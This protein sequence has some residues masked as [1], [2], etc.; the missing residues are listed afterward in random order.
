MFSG[1]IY[2]RG[3]SYFNQGRVTSLEFDP[4]KQLFF[5]QVTGTEMYDVAVK[6]TDS[7]IQ[8]TCGCPAFDKYFQCKHVCAVLLKIAD[9]KINESG[10]AKKEMLS[11]PTT[12]PKQERYKAAGQ[13]IELLANYEHF[14]PE[15]SMTLSRQL[16]KVEYFCKA[17]KNTSSLSVK[18]D[19]FTIELKVGVDRLYV[20]KNIREFLEKF[21]SQTSMF[22]T[23]KFTYDPA[24]Q[25]FLE[26]DMEII[27]LLL[28]IHKTEQLYRDSASYY[29][30]GSFYKERELT[31]PPSFADELFMKLKA[32]NCSI[33]IGTEI[34]GELKVNVDGLPFSFK[35]E[36]GSAN[37]FKLQFGELFSASYFETYGWLEYNGELYKLSPS[38]Q[39]LF[40]QLA[41]FMNRVSAGRFLPISKEQVGTFLSHSMPALN[42]IGKMEI[43][44]TISDQIISPPLRAK[45]FVDG[46][47]ERLEVKIEYHYGD[48]ILNPFEADDSN[49]IENG[50]ILMRD[51]G[52]ERELME[53]IESAP[54]KFN[55]KQLYLEGEEELYDFL[56]VTLPRIEEKA[57]IYL[58][59]SV[60]SLILPSQSSPAVSIDIDSSGDLL[61]VSFDM[62]GIDQENIYHILQS[63]VEKKKYVR[64]PGGAFLSLEKDEYKAMSE[65]I[66]EL[67]ISRT[68]L[69]KGKI[70]LPIYRGL[71]VDELLT[72]NNELQAKFG[73][74]FRTF[75]QSI[76]NPE[77][78][79]FQLPETL[80]A[81]LR[82]YQTTGFQW[83]KSLA[84]YRLGGILADDMGLG[85][86]LQAI[87]F[88]LSEKKE[89]KV[90]KPF[91]VV[92]PA[93][94]VYNWKSEFIKF[95]PELNVDV[96]L[97]TPNER[98]EILERPQLPDVL[99]TS[100]PT[101]RQDIDWYSKVE[102][103]TLILD[104]AQAIKNHAA[105]T[106]Q[107][108]RQ[109]NA[110]KRFALSGTPIENSLDEL[111]SIFQ[112]I[113]PG[114]FKNQKTF[115][116]LEPEQIS[117]V[118]RPFILRRVKKDVLKELPDKI[119]TV[120]E[121]ELTKNQ[122][123]LYIAYLEKIRQET[124]DS[125]E[126][127]GFQKGRIKILAGLTR[128]RQLCCHPS[129]FLEN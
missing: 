88:I 68:E 102:F 24:E 116:N 45:V 76:K 79:D 30:Q 52:K 113:L 73:K 114:L 127:E 44:E 31:I 81:T 36:K 42:Q 35:L 14:D 54:L 57:E 118:V 86:T 47:D 105:K 29:W 25:L 95:A 28:D 100:Y 65:L 43:S 75:L 109:V 59:N 46:N 40:K 99:I 93:S 96:V 70:E 82:D 60:R 92:A 41:T 18:K 58:T 91:L 62:K 64:L 5:A 19:F 23:K 108:V 6:I 8:G 124:K 90:S 12:R 2:K 21:E 66:N 112:A 89:A 48:F 69:E 38:Q 17:Y 80:Q 15:S 7:E 78:M 63:V 128:L 34:H 110:Q 119:E 32:R 9:G 3:V 85:K 120:H 55:G 67:N 20:V 125:L 49:V 111:W 26:E 74:S 39:S 101:L 106:S 104:E 33:Q 117:Q 123:E 11:K 37:D 121:S 129:L 98:K 27:K 97:G 71:Q 50:L 77:E 56:Y 87:A 103:D 51:T 16:L 1:T 22:F 107:A 84:H 94:L 126:K 72:R 61:D 53:T 13:F 122:K 4:V 115:R 83:L 10:A